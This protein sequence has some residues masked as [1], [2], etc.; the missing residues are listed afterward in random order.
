MPSSSVVAMVWSSKSLAGAVKMTRSPSSQGLRGLSKMQLRISLLS[1]STRALRQAIAFAVFLME[2]SPR[3]AAARRARSKSM[4]D[5]FQI[6]SS[7]LLSVAR[8]MLGAGWSTTARIAVASLRIWLSYRMTRCRCAPFLMPQTSED[9]SPTGGSCAGSPM[10]ST[11]KLNA[12][13]V[14]SRYRNRLLLTID[15]SST[16]IARYWD[17]SIGSSGWASSLISPFISSR[18]PSSE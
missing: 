9:F 4:M 7:P 8:R 15:A 2:K 1:T 10:N 17:K 14:S 3:A 6:P 13:A 18:K 5:S 11:F 16:T 12:T